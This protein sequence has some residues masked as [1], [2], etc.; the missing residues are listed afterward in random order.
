M[1]TEKI[2]LTSSKTRTKRIL[3]TTQKPKNTTDF[4][5]FSCSI[6]IPHFFLFSDNFTKYRGSKDEFLLNIFG[7]ALFSSKAQEMSFI[8]YTLS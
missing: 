8:C 6:L 2:Q 7:P 4:G 1:K 3:S 5:I